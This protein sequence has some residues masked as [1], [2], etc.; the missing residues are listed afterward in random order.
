MLEWFKERIG[1]AVTRWLTAEQPLA[2][3]EISPWDY[4]RICYELR[5]SDVI[6]VEGR[7]RVS[8]IIKR[9]TQSTWTHSALYIGRL[10]DITDPRM[11]RRVERHYNGD[12]TEPLLVEALLG[13][14]TIVTPLNRYR[15]CHLRICRPT[16]LSPED[17]RHVITYVINRLGTDY[18]LRQLVDLWRFMLPYSIIPR[19]WRSSLFQYQ[20]GMP[21]RT[22]CSSML[23]EAFT[24]VHFPV[25]PVFLRHDDGKV[26]LIKRN[27]RLYTPRD[28]DLS[29]FFAV[30]KCPYFGVEGMAPYRNLPWD[31][32][33]RIC[34]APGEVFEPPDTD[35]PAVLVPARTDN[36][37]DPPARPFSM[38]LWAPEL[39]PHRRIVRSIQRLLGRHTKA[40]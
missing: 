38:P 36:L 37:A 35:Y 31:E 10:H 5:P 17:S 15:D 7:A 14:G 28:F 8:T 20:P 6:L 39:V 13:R 3:G 11:R 22:L 26:R 30:I 9:A 29:P 12:P 25:R 16:G 34:N 4:E 1:G 21:S 40:G 27:T 33:N 19:R 23:A 24:S 2:P 18:D 32:N